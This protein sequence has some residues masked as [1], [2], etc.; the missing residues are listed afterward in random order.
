VAFKLKI[1]GSLG[2]CDCADTP[3][4]GCDCT[5]NCSLVCRVS[6]DEVFATLCGFSEFTEPSVPPKKYRR[7]TTSGE[8]VACLDL[9]EDCA[10]TP[11]TGQA[12][13]EANANDVPVGGTDP[14]INSKSG[15][16]RLEYLSTNE[17]G[18]IDTY[19][20]VAAAGTFK[21]YSGE[22]CD[23]PTAPPD[24]P[25][26]A[27]VSQT[28]TI[29]ILG[30]GGVGIFFTGT[31]ND[32]VTFATSQ[33]GITY[34]ILGRVG[35]DVITESTFTPLA[36]GIHG[37]YQ[38]T[39]AIVDQY[40]AEDCELDSTDESF[41]RL[42]GQ[43]RGAACGAAPDGNGDPLECT[44][45][46]DCYGAGIDLAEEDPTERVWEGQGCLEESGE[47]NLY[48]GEVTES[49]SDEDT[50]E[51]AI[52]RAAPA[53]DEETWQ[54]PE[55]CISAPAFMTARGEGDFE[56]AFRR[57]QARLYV[58]GGSVGQTWDVTIRF[59][60]RALASGG[61]WIFFAAEELT[62][63][64]T[65]EVDGAAT[66]WVEIP[67]EAGYETRAQGCTAELVEE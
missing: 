35:D 1:L 47:W 65:S 22:N 41:R 5:E 4:E 43:N 10:V 9:A 51:D 11:T 19:K 13:W 67:N 57:G 18:N 20:V 49:L 62:I 60:R 56:F 7:R 53:D 66:P 48:G 30:E 24:P 26:V 64:I 21:F 32:T 54:T 55:N 27:T 6:G 40:D 39:W 42:T 3:S 38:D 15:N 45:L 12:F 31:L 37:G 33:Q 16:W 61:P 63:T 58:V 25:C 36:G 14:Y 50:E 44:G 28:A 23:P 8:M 34:P 59:Y 29:R 17:A 2:C 52:E 46:V